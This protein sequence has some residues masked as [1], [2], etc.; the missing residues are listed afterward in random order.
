[1]DS[2]EQTAHN[3]SFLLNSSFEKQEHMLSGRKYNNLIGQ[4]RPQQMKYIPAVDDA[5]IWQFV[6]G[7]RMVPV[8]VAH[9]MAKDKN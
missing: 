3:L 9:V 6:P 1:M 2:Y 5:G 4:V 7:D 8:P